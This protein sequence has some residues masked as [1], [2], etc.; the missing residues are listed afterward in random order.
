MHN[1]KENYILTTDSEHIYPVECY[2]F[3]PERHDGLSGIAIESSNSHSTSWPLQLLP[4]N[5]GEQ[6]I[7]HS[8]TPGLLTHLL[9]QMSVYGPKQGC[10]QCYYGSP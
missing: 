9:S 7:T 1:K 3:G 4:R 8:M 6:S 10:V 2:L 5:N